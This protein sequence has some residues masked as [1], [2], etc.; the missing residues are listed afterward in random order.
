MLLHLEGQTYR[1][2]ADVVGM[3][4]SNVGV[5]LSRIKARFGDLARREFNGL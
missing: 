2:I 5:K 4:E 3:S 1:E